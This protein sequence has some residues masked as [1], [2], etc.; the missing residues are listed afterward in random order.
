MQLKFLKRLSDIQTDRQRRF[1]KV[2][3]I[4]YYTMRKE[5]KPVFDVDAAF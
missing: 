4:A 2:E 3:G 5:F 1:L